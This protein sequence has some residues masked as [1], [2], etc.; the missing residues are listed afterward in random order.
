MIILYFNDFEALGEEQIEQ[1]LS[2]MP[3]QQQEA[4]A[5]TK[6]LSRKREIAISYLMLC[7]AIKHSQEEIQSRKTFINVFPSPNWQ[8]A[9]DNWQLSTVNCQFTIAEH[10]KPYLTNYEGVFFNISHCKEAVAV[11]IGR[12]EIG[13]DIEGCRRYSETLLQRA[14]TDEEQESI[15]HNAEPMMEFA[16]LW[17]RK[18]AFFKWTGTGILIDHIKSVE[19]DALAA[20][21]DIS[22][23]LVIPARGN[24]FFLSIAV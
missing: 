15:R 22:T 23:Q 2:W 21:C 5:G 19:Q 1:L 14:F 24:P 3:Q 17:T 8:L 12:Q 7:Y 16:R 10:G 6:L 13:V 9:I 18:E 4:I 11:G 20:G